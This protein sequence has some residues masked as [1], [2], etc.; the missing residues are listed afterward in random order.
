MRILFFLLALATTIALVVIL[1]TTKLLPAP[2]GRWLSPQQG[3]WQN[4]ESLDH[5]YNANLTIPGLKGSTEVY[6]DERLVPHIFSDNEEDPYFVQGYLHAKFRL[7]QMEFQTR[8]ISGRISEI[9]G[10]AGIKSDRGFRRMGIT[11]A[12]ESSLAFME[13]DEVMRQT[14]DAY[15]AGVNAYIENLPE[16][17]LPI[18]YKILGYKPEKWTN[19][20]SVLF[21]KAMSYDLVGGDDDFEQTNL[22]KILGEADYHLLFPQAE[23]SLSPIIPKGIPFTKSAEI[24]LAPA[25]A[26]SVYFHRRDSLWFTQEFKPDPD[27]GS[28]NW[29]VSGA[30]TKSGKPILCN[31]PHLSL[32]LPSIWMEMQITTPTSNAYGVTF[33][34][35]PIVVIGFN[36][37][38]AF[39]V[40]NAGRELK[41]YYEIRF[42]D[43][44]RTEYWF[45]NAWKKADLRIEQISVKGSTPFIDTVAY[46][47]FGPVI[48]DK[49]F[50][51]KLNQNK[52][53]ALN[54][55]AHYPS[56]PL[57]MWYQLNRAKNYND[58]LEAV[59]YFN[60]PS[61][62][63][64]F[65]SKEGDIAIKQEGKFPLRWEGQGSFVMPGTDS[66]YM[67]KEFIPRQDNPFSHN[68]EQGYLS[69]ANQRAV[70]TSYPY[71]IPGS[72]DMYRGVSINRRLSVMSN[73]TPDD[74]KRLQNDNY[75]VFAEHM[76]PLLLRY[77]DRDRLSPEALRFLSLLEQWNLNSDIQEKGP[78]IF[79]NWVD[80]LRPA[81][82]RDELF[83]NDLPVIFPSDEVIAQ[84]LIRDSTSFKFIDNI[85]TPETETLA[86]I[87]TSSL[88]KATPGLK[89]AEDD[90]RLE[91][92]NFKNTS[93]YHLL[94]E[95]MLP[96]ARQGLPIG[97]GKHIINATKH[98][99]GPS[100]KMVI[101]MTTPT[102]A[103]GIY[104]GGQ[105]GNPGSPFYDNT[106]LDWA[107]GQ[108]Y[109]LW[110]MQQKE[111]EDKRVKATMKFSS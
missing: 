70:D 65:A 44:S 46:T 87:L 79:E 55:I 93:V 2:L 49:T 104:P 42:K 13:K 50:K 4:A 94:R 110:V 68:P 28:N 106:V 95:R 11:S 73:I 96:F 103:Y 99:N 43:A 84:C 24:P 102:E 5:D 98:K 54:W 35:L 32:S 56:N 41:D 82:F 100:W 23:D 27:N 71:F 90:H 97:G 39:G 45:N 48:Y 29:V 85:I 76:R 20:K 21:F 74:M 108:H 6:F 33:P 67:W 80:S 78:T 75:N 37:Y 61:Q 31:D 52:A 12:A 1:D 25:D 111:K 9:V 57:K 60:E 16:S 81:L 22:L 34:G 51:D 66:S 15:T 30:K 40:T 18:E 3:I 59:Q 109:K 88:E 53:Y 47:V 19:L 62:N 72:Y 63:I 26:D 58:Y 77:V 91:W 8:F 36:D 17:Q 7:W 64:V 92:G 86:D 101:H 14:M 38:I 10:D 83:R 69:S 89:K 107:K 105:N